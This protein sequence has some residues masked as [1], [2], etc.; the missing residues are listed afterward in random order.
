VALRVSVALAWWRWPGGASSVG[1]AGLVIAGL[2]IGGLVAL[3]VSVAL[4]PRR[5]SQSK[6]NF[7]RL[8]REAPPRGG[9]RLICLGGTPHANLRRRDLYAV[10]FSKFEE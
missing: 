10:N 9:P 1:G 3:R 5:S 6:N 2:V 4:R 7:R 8:A